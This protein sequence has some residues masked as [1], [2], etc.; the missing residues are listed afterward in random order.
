MVR[1][2]FGGLPATFWVLFSG[3]LVNRIGGMVTAFLVLYLTERG[4]SPANIGLVLA[5]H[6]AG[7]LASQPLG[8]VLADR[9]GR[10]FTMLLGLLTT[11][12]SLAL[13]GAA[14]HVNAIV[15]A[16]ATLGLVAEIYRPASAAMVADVVPAEL[17]AKAYG[18]LFWA[19]N[20]GF[21]AASVMAGFLAQHGYWL[22]FAVD[23]GTGLLFSII[24][25]FGIPADSARSEVAARSGSGYLSAVRD[26]LLVSL[27]LVTMGYAAIYHQWQ[28]TV[29]LAVHDQGLS[30]SAY[31]VIA[32]LNGILI[33]FLQPLLTPLLDRFDRMRV[34]AVSSALIGAGMALT[35]LAHTAWQFALTVVVWTVGEVCTAGFAA[36]LA[37]DIAPATARGRYQAMFGWSWGVAMLIGSTGGT[38][39]YGTVG[40]AS[41]WISCLVV[42]TA[43]AVGCL[44]LVS[45]VRGRTQ[46]AAPAVAL[47][48]C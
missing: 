45:R 27:M 47:K 19:I 40:P 10:R 21:A 6:G 29:P 39:A 41:V 31:G 15:V 44:L 35:G 12:G 23:A 18:L 14:A 24:V 46:R 11:S 30:T 3:Q 16:A 42:G 17:R 20:L 48:T 1:H 28:V 9:V 8:G 38:W 5:A 13:L 22:L 32:A 43:S 34:L 26:P 37:A 25:V 4:L 2:H 33:V 7:S 36:A